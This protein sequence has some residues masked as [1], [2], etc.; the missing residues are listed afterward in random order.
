MLRPVRKMAPSGCQ[1]H[2]RFG[3]HR[4]VRFCASAALVWGAQLPAFA[5]YNNPATTRVRRHCEQN[6]ARA[7]ASCDVPQELTND[8]IDQELGSDVRTCPLPCSSPVPACA[9]IIASLQHRRPGDLV[10]QT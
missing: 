6:P 3:R 9:W 5:H 7:F 4:L 1:H 8:E 2:K 10:P